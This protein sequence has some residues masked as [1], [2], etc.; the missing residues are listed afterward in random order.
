MDSFEQ[1]VIEKMEEL[2]NVLE[3]LNAATKDR[4]PQGHLRV[5]SS[6]GRA[7]YYYVSEEE[8]QPA[9]GAYIRKSEL[10]QARKLAQREYSEE[11]KK[12]VISE[13][14]MLQSCLDKCRRSKLYGYYDSLSYY[15]QVLIEP[16]IVSDERFRQEWENEVYTGKDFDDD[17][18]EIITEKGERVRSKSEKMIADKLYM[19]GIPYKYEYPIE[20]KGYGTVYS[21]FRLL[22][23]VRRRIV[24]MEHLGMMDD[25]FYASKALKKIECYERNG[26]IP[27]INL[28]ITH[29]TSDRP[30]DMR[31]VTKLLESVLGLE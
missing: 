30:L 26:F 19:M 2:R 21:D 31:I 9:G 14:E 24:I 12:M 18:P 3:L 28:I 20:L 7:R 10:Y 11:M 1:A 22:D 23:V 27:G 5:T 13:L 15:R 6:N 8:R 17:Q 25:P 16:V 29:E 4:P